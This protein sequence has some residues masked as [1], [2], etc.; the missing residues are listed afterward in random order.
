[1]SAADGVV[2]APARPR[3]PRA[4]LG[5]VAA[6]AAWEL[7]A[8]ALDGTYLLAGPAAILAHLAENAGLLSR[9][10]GETLRS[11]ALGYP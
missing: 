1:M 11:A 4:A 6:L 3:L 7:L 10:L 5:L 2:P 8:R 9:A